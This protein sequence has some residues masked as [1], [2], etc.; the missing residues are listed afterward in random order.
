MAQLQQFGGRWTIEKLNIF[1]DY[2]NFYVQALKKQRFKKIYIDAFAGTGSIDIGDQW[3]TFDIE[4]SVQIALSAKEE[5]DH[6]YFIELDPN[7]C[8]ELRKIV[9]TKYPD[10][11]SKVDII[12]G[13]AGTEVK[14]LCS[15]IDWKASRAL[16]FLDP[17]AMQVSWDVLTAI[18]N[19][20]SIDLWYLFPLSATTRLLK[21]DGKM[22]ESWKNKLNQVFGDN[23]WEK[24]M[25]SESPQG[26]LFGELDIVKESTDKLV[27]Y[28]QKKLKQEFPFVSSKNRILYNSKKSPLFLLCF[29]VSNPSNKAWGLAQ[30]V[31]DHI[32]NG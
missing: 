12:Q 7:K 15:Q 2:L 1:S 31:A 11:A 16:L 19:T 22:D 28:I 14:R 6:Y 26:N 23:S 21:K 24:E 8:Q 20:Q 4:G 29:A 25:Y 5:F 13:D 32:L 27:L 9:A 10:R 3:E 18:K 30:K 17:C